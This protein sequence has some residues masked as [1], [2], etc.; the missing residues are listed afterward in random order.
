MDATAA[1]AKIGTNVAKINEQNQEYEVIGN[2]QNIS[3]GFRI[4]NVTNIEDLST[5]IAKA[6]SAS[7]KMAGISINKAHIVFNGGKQSSIIYNSE[8]PI[9]NGEIND[10]E[11]QKLI[12]LAI[13]E[14]NK[15]KNS[16]N[17]AL[18]PEG[19][20]VSSNFQANRGRLPWPVKEG[21]I[22]RRFGT[23]PHP[24]V[25]TTTINSNGISIATSSNSIAYSVFDGEVLSVDIKQANVDYANKLTSE[26]TSVYCQDSVEFLWGLSEKEKI[27]LLY[28]DSYDFEADNPIPSQLHHVKELCAVMKNLKKGTIIVV[29][30]HLNTPEFESLRSTFAKGGKAAFVENFMDS[31]GAECLHDGYQIVWRL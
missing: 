25:R 18:T 23:Q 31:I 4:G 9:V 5:C 11:I 19:R 2:S 7:E 10:N 24:V 21:V 26:R 6:V 29:D 15:N 8:T 1:P 3:R 27:D 17:F 30:D 12:R 13:A 16:T 22:V 14:S 20:I 28:L